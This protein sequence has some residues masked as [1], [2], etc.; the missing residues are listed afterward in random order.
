[1]HPIC[2]FLVLGQFYYT[3]F[4]TAK[5]LLRKLYTTKATLTYHNF[6]FKGLITNHSTANQFYCNLITSI[7]RGVSYT[8]CITGFCV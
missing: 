7:I 1:M 8:K 4:C 3:L 6:L 2:S 5:T